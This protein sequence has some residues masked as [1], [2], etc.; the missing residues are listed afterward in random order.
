M[1]S[2]RLLDSTRPPRWNF[3]WRKLQASLPVLMTRNWEDTSSPPSFPQRKCAEW[4]SC[5]KTSL[6]KV[7]DLKKR[8]Q[9]FSNPVSGLKKKTWDMRRK[10]TPESLQLAKT[11]EPWTPRST[12]DL[13]LPRNEVEGLGS[14]GWGSGEPQVFFLV[15]GFTPLKNLLVKMGIFPNFQGENKKYLKPPPSFSN[16]S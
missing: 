8:Y 10:I 2:P 3:S 16:K 15:G 7:G 9:P 11:P 1:P 13:H 5:F 4:M 12:H 14:L 6:K